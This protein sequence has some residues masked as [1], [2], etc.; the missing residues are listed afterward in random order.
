MDTYLST[1]FYPSPKRAQA[2]DLGVDI[3]LHKRN[4]YDSLTQVDHGQEQTHVE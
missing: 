4:L 3:M 1:K 2:R